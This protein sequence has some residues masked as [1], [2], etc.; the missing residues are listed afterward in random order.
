MRRIPVFSTTLH[1]VGYDRRTCVLEAEFRTG[2]VYRYFL[3]P[4]SA[5]EGL[6]RASSKGS[7][8]NQ[9]IRDR[10]RYEHV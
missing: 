8:F 3:V 7:Y 1:A 2:E 10:F 6:M 4:P 5:F 9:K